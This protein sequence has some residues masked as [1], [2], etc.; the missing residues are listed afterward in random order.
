MTA[1]PHAP[2]PP[3]LDALAWDPAPV[4]GELFAF[5]RENGLD[6]VRARDDTATGSC[7]DLCPEFFSPSGCTRGD[8]CQWRHA[9]NDRL[10]VC[11]HYLRGLW[12]VSTQVCARGVVVGG[13]SSRG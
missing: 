10:T 8:R 12:Y 1:V 3:L 4:Y 11:K 6:E 7:T 9:R 13:G 2:A 5:E